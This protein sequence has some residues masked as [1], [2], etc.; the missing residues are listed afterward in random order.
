MVEKM[1]PGSVIVDLA[2]EAGGNC[3]LTEPGK[4]VV[5]NAVKICGPTNLPAELPRDSSVL[6]SRNLTTFFLE[7]WKEGAFRLAL[8]DEIIRGAMVTHNG[9]IVHAGARDAA[10]KG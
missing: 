2:A 3:E 6:Y 1:S 10:A 8:D 7:F 4:T 5:R 9:E